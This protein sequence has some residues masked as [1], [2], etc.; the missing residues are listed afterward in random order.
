MKKIKVTFF[1][2]LT[3]AVTL[4]IFSNSLKNIQQSNEASG[5]FIEWLGSV[6]RF[7][8]G[9]GADVYFIVRKGAHLAEFF[10][11]GFFVM[12]AVSEIKKKISGI[13]GFGFF[14]VLLVAVTDEYIQSFFDR[15]SSVSDVLIDFAGAMLGF[16]GCILLNSLIKTISQRLSNKEKKVENN[17]RGN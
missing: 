16:C 11:L 4:F 12:N 2:F 5:V 10:A 14:Y 17:G 8:F 1:L 9:E 7:I 6:V 3:A 13:T 15:T